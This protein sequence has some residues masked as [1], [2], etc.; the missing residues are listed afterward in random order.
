MSDVFE[1]LCK[2]IEKY[3]EALRTILGSC[4]KLQSSSDS[5][6]STIGRVYADYIERMLRSPDEVQ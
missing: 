3:E 4:K 2:R 6:I 5:D 1:Q